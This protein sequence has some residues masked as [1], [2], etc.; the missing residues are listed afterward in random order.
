[1]PN[2]FGKADIFG[3]TRPT[4][5][6]TIQFGGMQ[7]N[8]VVLLRSDVV[9]QSDATTMNST[10]LILP[11]QQQTNITGTVGTRPINGTATTTSTAY[12]PPRGSTSINS[13]QPTIPILV[14]WQTN[15]R[16]PVLGRTIVIEAAN[17]TSLNYR[18]E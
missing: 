1:M 3:R 16:V 14:D 11:T 18:V 2:A 6:T 13:Q 10:G 17:P 4:G 5:F 7:E 8:K 15:P 12:I 9:T